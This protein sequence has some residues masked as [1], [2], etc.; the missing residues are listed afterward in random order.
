LL[1]SA[2]IWL[3]IDGAFIVTS[4]EEQ[5]GAKLKQER[6]DGN[7]YLEKKEANCMKNDARG[8]SLT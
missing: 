6:L 3:T 4:I 8:V 2:T 7:K 5:M 1:L